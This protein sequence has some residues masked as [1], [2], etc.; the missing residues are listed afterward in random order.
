MIIWGGEKREDHRG[1]GPVTITSLGSSLL[2]EGKSSAQIV[3]VPEESPSPCQLFQL[4]VGG[5]PATLWVERE[6]KD[7]H[8]GLKGRV[9]NAGA[10]LSRD[11]FHPLKLPAGLCRGLDFKW[12]DVRV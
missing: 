7:P 4:P 1:P 3:R 11:I 9:T 5:A 8:S 12:Q 6:G 2:G 10:K